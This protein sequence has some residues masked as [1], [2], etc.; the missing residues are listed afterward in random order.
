MK[1]IR[2]FFDRETTLSLIED[3]AG[4]AAICILFFVGLGLPSLV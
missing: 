2:Q 3:V 4:L 1:P